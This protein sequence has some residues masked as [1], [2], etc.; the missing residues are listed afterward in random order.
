MIKVFLSYSHKDE[1]LQKELNEHLG[2][3]KHERIIDTWWDGRIPPGNN[4]NEDIARQLDAA[5][6]IL[7]L[8]SS[9][10]LDSTY[11][12]AK[13]LRRAIER[14]DAGTA[15]VVPIILRPCHWEPAPFAKL[16]GLPKGMVPVTTVPEDKRDAIWAEVAKGI[17]QAVVT[18]SAGRGSG[19][20][21]SNPHLTV[22][23]TGVLSVDEQGLD[24]ILE[25]FKEGDN[26][27]I[28]WPKSSDQLISLTQQVIKKFDE[29]N[30]TFVG[31]DEFIKTGPAALRDTFSYRAKCEKRL[32]QLI[33]IMSAFGEQRANP[34]L[35][36][37]YRKLRVDAV[38]FYLLRANFF[39]HWKLAYLSSWQDLNRLDLRAPAVWIPY[40]GI[41]S[42]EFY[43]R[44]Y[45]DSEAETTARIRLR[46][47]GDY[48][49]T[50]GGGQSWI[51]IDV[52]RRTVDEF[53]NFL[54]DDSTICRWAIPQVELSDEL[55]I[56]PDTY[57]GKWVGYRH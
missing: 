36:E 21:G 38:K 41:P 50:R 17:H 24:R 1:A 10:F 11:C 57:N 46:E 44:L 45:D 52:P 20:D 13:E 49:V 39:A 14:H 19:A 3:L 18:C 53:G 33:S 15:R 37:S 54:R 8:V 29:E 43:R 40:Q 35:K 28:K 30:I 31:S 6:L 16:Q 51:Y 4:W 2:A 56:L 25:H 9:G 12:Y 5:D 47:I 32:P 48:K 27:D 34:S 26:V 23:L 55:N 42:N 22:A 7:L